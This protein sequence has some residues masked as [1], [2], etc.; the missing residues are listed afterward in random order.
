[1][2]RQT[3]AVVLTLCTLAAGAL[4]Q[5]ASLPAKPE[6]VPKS[7]LISSTPTPPNIEGK[8]NAALA[9]YQI[10]ELLSKEQKQE[11][12]EGFASLNDADL[13]GEA[14][15]KLLAERQAYIQ[16]ILRATEISDCDW[17]VQYQEGFGALLPHL[18]LL[19]GYA[20]CLAFDSRRCLA[21]GDKKGASERIGAMY[22]L[23]VHSSRGGF[24]IG[25]LVG[26]AIQAL[27]N[28]EVRRQ[29]EAGRLDVETARAMLSAARGNVGE[30]TL[31]YRAAIDIESFMA[32]DWVQSRYTG[33]DAGKQLVADLGEVND[34]DS[35]YGAVEGM[36]GETLG[37]EAEKSRGYYD[38]VKAAWGSP[39]AKE[40]LGSLGEEVTAGKFGKFTFLIGAF[41]RCH[42]TMLKGKADLANLIKTLEAFVRG[43]YTPG[44][45]KNGAQ[46][47]A[48]TS[49]PVPA[50][51]T[52][53]PAPAA[54]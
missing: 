28:S 33:R 20:R 34:D 39:D 18:G 36:D 37:R 13:P 21:E 48:A 53:K 12:A 15:R 5:P 11:L 54:K 1:M 31:G 32:V 14:A 47:E 9:Y 42:S 8:R 19:R 30:D 52:T 16:R 4:A 35:K 46:G 40:K 6:A 29:L 17:G 41:D 38:A 25:S 45:A 44:Q 22:R 10:N 23:S 50:S 27:A 49:A 2:K 43:E 51:P 26:E 3:P 24:L 7:L